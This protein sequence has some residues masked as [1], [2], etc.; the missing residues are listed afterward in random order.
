MTEQEKKQRIAELRSELKE[1]AACL[2]E[3][4]R[5]LQEKP[6][7]RDISYMAS[8]KHKVICCF[9]CG[10]YYESLPACPRCGSRENVLKKQ[11]VIIEY[12]YS[13][14]LYHDIGKLLIIDTIAMYGRKL[15]DS[16]FALLK[17]HPENGAEMA[18]KYE[19]FKEYSDVIK[20][21][22]LWYDCS[23]GYPA[24]FLTGDSPLKTIIDIV[25]VADCMDAATDTVGR[26]YNKGKTLDDY[27]LEVEQD[28]G[29]RY[30][31]WAPDLLKEPEVKKDLEYLLEKERLKIYGETYSLLR[32]VRSGE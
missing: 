23:R 16:E 32:D 7:S 3:Y 4:I 21:H 17:K 6:R 22:H 20:G 2:Q 5:Y 9:R 14:A 15:L 1:L 12:C 30:A 19:S 26:S 27:I 28:A 8:D 25:A 13:S 29:T 31:P 11:N 18:E 24:D 10:F